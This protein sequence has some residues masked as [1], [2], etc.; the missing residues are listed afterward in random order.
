MEEER[1]VA[2]RLKENRELHR[3]IERHGISQADLVAALK[4]LRADGHDTD[5]LWTLIT[6]AA[7]MKKS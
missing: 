1:F 2:E 3:V 6:H 4:N 7:K 5:D